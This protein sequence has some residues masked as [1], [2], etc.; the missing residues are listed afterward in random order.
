MNAES[1]NTV[2]RWLVWTLISNNTP[3]ILTTHQGNRK[4]HRGFPL[5]MFSYVIPDTDNFF[6][7]NPIK[8]DSDIVTHQ[9]A[10]HK[11]YLLDI[12]SSSILDASNGISKDTVSNQYGTWYRWCTLLKHLGSIPQ[13]QRTIIV[14]SFAASVQRNRFGTTRKQKILHGT[15]KSAISDVSASFY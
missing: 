5:T 15:V 13:Y 14:S 7:L 8:I 1:H 4:H 9:T 12:I 10:A 11:L 6:Q 2:A 3:Y